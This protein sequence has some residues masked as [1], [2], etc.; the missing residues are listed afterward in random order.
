MFVRHRQNAANYIVPSLYAGHLPEMVCFRPRRC[1]CID[2][3]SRQSA[4]KPIFSADHV[5]GH[6]RVGCE[7]DENVMHES[8]RQDTMIG[9]KVQVWRCSSRP[10]VAD[11]KSP[12]ILTTY[13]RYIF[14][15]GGVQDT[16]VPTHG[17]LHMLDRASYEGRGWG[18]EEGSCVDPD[19]RNSYE[20]GLSYCLKRLHNYSNYL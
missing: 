4:V 2:Y 19:C 7:A 15:E 10:A 3:Q 1:D 17:W 8:R 13:R 20:T 12:C 14:V 6:Q 11:D 5:T 9:T 18:A 16:A